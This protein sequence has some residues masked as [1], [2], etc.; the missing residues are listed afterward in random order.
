MKCPH[1]GSSMVYGKFYGSQEHFWG[2]KCL[3][4]GEI[5]DNTI[6]ENRMIQIG[7]RGLFKR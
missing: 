3:F 4:C 6:L 5:F 1:C 2:W 7:V